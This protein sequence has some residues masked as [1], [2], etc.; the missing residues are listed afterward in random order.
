MSMLIGAMLGDRAAGYF[1][2]I[3]TKK[4]RERMPWGLTTP[5]ALPCKFVLAK[6]V[7]LPLVSSKV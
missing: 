2:K 4:C 6:P 1:V 7:Y 5:D 3:S